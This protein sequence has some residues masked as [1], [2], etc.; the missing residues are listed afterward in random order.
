MQAQVALAADSHA[1][2]PVAEHLDTH[3]LARR[4]EHRSRADLAVDGLHA[5]ERQF[6]GENDNVGPLRIHLHRLDVGN[7]GL[8]G[9]MHLHALAPGAGYGRRIGR[10]YGRDARLG[11]SVD[12][13]VEQRYVVVVDDSVDGKIC[14]H[15][16]MRAERCYAAEIVESEIGARPRTHVEPLHSEVDGV[17]SGPDGRLKRL[18]GTHGRHYFKILTFH[19]RCMCVS[20]VQK[21]MPALRIKAAND[22][23]KRSLDSRG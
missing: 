6:T 2:R 20:D 3:R 19:C 15:P 18:I 14:L 21:L 9:D 13:I 12:N 22:S 7:I 17:G 16:R 11:R 10:N 1:E 23:E 5:V 4:A 8:R